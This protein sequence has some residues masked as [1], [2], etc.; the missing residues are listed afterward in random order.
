MA[1][2]PFPR[3]IGTGFFGDERGIVVTN[4]HVIE[5]L[6]QLPR[7]PNGKSSA[8][9]LVFPNV[10][11]TPERIRMWTLQVAIRK[12]TRITRVDRPP[13]YVNYGQEVPD[14]GF[15]WLNLRDVPTLH[16]A[17]K[18]DLLQTGLEIAT[19]GF[20]LG[21]A[22]LH[23]YGNINQLTPFL[24]RGIVS[25][26][27]PFECPRPHGFTIDIMSQGGASGSPI[28]LTNKPTVVGIIHGGIP[29]TNFT[30]AVPSREIADA[31]KQFGAAFSD[32]SRV[33]TL[34]EHIA[35]ARTEATG[36]FEAEL[37]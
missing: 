4:N 26:V 19:A 30:Y 21:D 29:G 27:L 18:P 7:L 22:P 6:K 13:G 16:I 11:E 5:A 31:I 36:P 2:V 14:I 9:A 23:T 34:T 24:R 1:T 17:D 25:S 32:I 12:Y 28:F 15:V 8:F 3:I 33:P 37:L 20:P 10:E 35:A